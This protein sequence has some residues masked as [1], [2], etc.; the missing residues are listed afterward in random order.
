M[1]PPA[2]A[3]Y[4]LS[5]TGRFAKR[6]QRRLRFLRESCGGHPSAS[7]FSR[8]RACGV[9]TCSSTSSARHSRSRSGGQP[10]TSSSAC[11]EPPRHLRRRLPRAPRAGPAPRRH[12]A[13]PTPSRP[14]R[15]RSNCVA[16]EVGDEPGESLRVGFRRRPQALGGAR[17]T[18]RAGSAA[19]R[20]TARYAAAASSLARA[21]QSALSATASRASRR[22]RPDP[23]P[24]PCRPGWPRPGGGRPA[25]SSRTRM[26]SSWPRGRGAACRSPPPTDTRRHRG[27]R[28]P[29]CGRRCKTPPP[30]PAGRC[31]AS[32]GLPGR[33]PRPKA[34]PPPARPSRQ[35][36]R[37]GRRWPAGCRRARRRGHRRTPG[38]STISSAP[39]RWRRPR[40]A[41]SRRR[42]RGARVDARR[43][44]RLA[45]R[46]E[47]HARDAPAVALEALQLLARGHVPQAKQGVTTAR[48]HPLAVGAEGAQGARFAGQAPQLLARGDL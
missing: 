45:V 27:R 4:V 39:S 38:G 29:G 7:A 5:G 35:S 37:G 36:A 10:S 20:R 16:V 48:H 14:P 41:T 1:P 18:A 42:R 26:S 44:Q 21:S 40:R 8:S 12:P 43:G 19:S 22:A 25:R 24:G 34:V 33:S 31:P 2:S 46:R 9:A 6:L 32:T 23:R 30:E 13:S 47:G 28:W 15:A 3:A 17:A 11:R